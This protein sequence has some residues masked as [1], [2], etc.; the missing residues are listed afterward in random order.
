MRQRA[1]R[2]L[3][4][5]SGAALRRRRGERERERDGEAEEEEEAAAAMLMAWDL[6]SSGGAAGEPG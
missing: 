3:D 2:G 4:F 6:L 1:A 5:P